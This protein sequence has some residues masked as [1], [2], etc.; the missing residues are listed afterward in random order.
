MS[1]GARTRVV[2]AIVA[3]RNP[4]IA[5]PLAINRYDLASVHGARLLAERAVV[6]EAAQRIDGGTLARLETSM[7]AQKHCLDDPV[8]FLI[9]DREF[10]T[11]I[12]RCSSNP[13]LSDFVD[14]AVH[15]SD[16]APPDGDVAARRH[17]PCSFKDHSEILA[18]LRA[19][20][21]AAVVAAF[22]HHLDRIYNTTRAILDAIRGATLPQP[23]PSESE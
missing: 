9:C 4:D 12:Y 16:G 1:Q 3:G 15:L 6:A 2:S 10:H 11:A 13:L 23:L 20:D 7:A 5:S 21:A 14:R 19:R 22:E 17:S 18:G 8:R